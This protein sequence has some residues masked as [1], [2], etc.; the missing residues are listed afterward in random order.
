MLAED[1]RIW[2]ELIR[3]SG[4]T[5][6]DLCNLKYPN[7]LESDI[8]KYPSCFLRSATMESSPG[9]AGGSRNETDTP[10]GAPPPKEGE[11]SG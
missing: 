11:I 9:K 2:I 10:T 4:T 8:R 7:A 6:T 5:H 3:D 1:G